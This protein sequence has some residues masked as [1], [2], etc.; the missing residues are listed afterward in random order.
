VGGSSL[1]SPDPHLPLVAP[2]GSTGKPKGILHTTGGY[3]LFATFTHKITFD[4]RDGDVYA[5]VAD[6]GWI[7]GHSYILYVNVNVDVNE[8]RLGFSNTSR[9][10]EGVLVCGGDA[11]GVTMHC[12]RV[13]TP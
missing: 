2:L 1:T 12:R 3:L 8:R 13:R 4:Y 7:T 5:C 11:L 9:N 10:T 6:C